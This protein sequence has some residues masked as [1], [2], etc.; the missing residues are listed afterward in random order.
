MQQ[1]FRIIGISGSLRRTSANT[2][3]LRAIQ[4]AHTTADMELVQL[5]EIPAYNEDDDG[6]A[7]ARRR[8]RIARDASPPRMP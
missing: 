3:I 7:T 1:R 5:N 2:A 4:E 6:A 8:P